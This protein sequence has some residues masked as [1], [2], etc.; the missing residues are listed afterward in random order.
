MLQ[1]NQKCYQQ[2]WERVR[3]KWTTYTHAQNAKK[4]ETECIYLTGGRNPREDTTKSFMFLPRNRCMELFR[5]LKIWTL[6]SKLATFCICFCHG[7]TF[8]QKI[9]D[10]T[11][12]I[13]RADRFSLTL[14]GIDLYVYKLF[15]RTLGCLFVF[16]VNK[17]APS[18]GTEITHIN[19]YIRTYIIYIYK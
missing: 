9:N 2:S 18:N 14:V 13:S 11:E 17:L 5:Q 1:L 19:R 15:I 12:S 4:S 7:L 3:E 16:N 8:Y 6:T 10:N